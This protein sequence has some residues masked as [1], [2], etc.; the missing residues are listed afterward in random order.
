MAANKC[1]HPQHTHD[2]NRCKFLGR[3]GEIDVYVCTLPPRPG[4]THTHVSLIGR[5]GSEGYENASSNPPWYFAGPAEYMH[6]ACGWYHHAWRGILAQ[7]LLTE[8]ERKRI[9]DLYREAEQ[10]YDIKPTWWVK[11][12]GEERMQDM[13]D[14]YRQ[15]EVGS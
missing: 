1:D 12:R 7:E 2:C 5:Y 13:K 6:V 3:D 15:E 8:G 4:A 11:L 9:G 10:R 14:K